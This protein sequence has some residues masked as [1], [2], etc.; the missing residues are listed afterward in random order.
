[1]STSMSPSGSSS[2]SASVSPSFGADSYFYACGINRDGSKGGPPALFAELDLAT[3]IGHNI[4]FGAS[5]TIT[6]DGGESG[7][8]FTL[9]SGVP[10]FHTLLGAPVIYR[11]WE[12]RILIGVKRY[13][14]R[15]FVGELWMGLLRSTRGPV[16][17]F[18]VM[19]DDLAQASVIGAVGHVAAWSDGGRPFRAFKMV[20]KDRVASYVEVRDQ[21]LG[22]TREGVDPMLLIPLGVMESVGVP[23]H[24]R[25]GKATE[26]V[27]GNPALQVFSLTLEESS[28]PRV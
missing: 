8:V 11:Y 21:L 6:E 4:P 1:M 16:P 10:S 12:L 20:F 25:V 5:V 19:R 7:T 17:T 2:P 13:H 18:S 3:F 15:P 28:F 22:A 27:Q 14:E 9:A 24:G 23:I 26:F